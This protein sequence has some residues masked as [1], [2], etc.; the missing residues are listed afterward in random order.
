LLTICVKTAYR[1]SLISVVDVSFSLT[2]A[3]CDGY[4]IAD[5]WQI[6]KCPAERAEEVK[7]KLQDK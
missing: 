7:T 6:H 1:S 2:S 3:F 5:P 4:N